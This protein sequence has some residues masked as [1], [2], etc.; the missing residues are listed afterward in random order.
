MTDSNALIAGN[1]IQP[2]APCQHL[3]T[4]LLL[5]L[6]V[7]SYSAPVVFSTLST[8]AKGDTSNGNALISNYH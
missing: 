8:R 6:S 3:L 7:M 1:P 5:L 4:E 2:D